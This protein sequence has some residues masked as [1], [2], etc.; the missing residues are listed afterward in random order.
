MNR[1][2]RRAAQAVSRLSQRKQASDAMAE[3]VMVDYKH[4]PVRDVRKHLE[5][6]KLPK[7]CVDATLEKY[8]NFLRQNRTV[9][10]SIKGCG[11]DAIVA[12]IMFALSEDKRKLLTQ[13]V[14]ACPGHYPAM[15]QQLQAAY[16]ESTLD[17]GKSGG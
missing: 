3:I 5:A 6:L 17:D 1:K 2:Q 11:K 4:I 15:E 12:N 16:T 14:C 10:C 13:M 9:T 8:K 7:G